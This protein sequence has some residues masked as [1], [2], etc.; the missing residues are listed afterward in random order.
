MPEIARQ[1]LADPVLVGMIALAVFLNVGAL[2]L[3]WDHRRE[4]M[5]SAEPQADRE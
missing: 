5:A 2:G 3:K 1:V 4:K